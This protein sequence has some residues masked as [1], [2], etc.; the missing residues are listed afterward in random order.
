MIDVHNDK[1]LGDDLIFAFNRKIVTDS[2]P[3]PMTY[4]IMRVG[5]LFLFVCLFVP[6][7]GAR[8]GFH[9]GVQALNSI[10]KG[11]VIPTTFIALLHQWSCLTA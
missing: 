6:N 7:N 10:R 9:L 2:F 3:G 8:N 11:F 1:S 5:F 4:L